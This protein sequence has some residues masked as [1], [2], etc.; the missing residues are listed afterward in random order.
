[1]ASQ[2]QFD[3][4]F[5]ATPERISF[6]Y[7]LAGLGS[8]FLAQLLDLLILAVAVAVLGFGSLAMGGTTGLLVIVL[9]SFILVNGYFLFFEGLWS[10]Q[11]PGKRVARLRVV[12]GSGQPITFE[13]A[14][15]RNLVRNLDFLPIG[16]GVGLIA[17]FAH[18]HGK[19]LGDLAADTV[20]V[21][22]RSSLT[23]A[24][25]V[26]MAQRTLEITPADSGAARVPIDASYTRQRAIRDLEPSLRDFVTAYAGRRPSLGLAYRA[27]LAESARAGLSRALPQVVADHGALAALDQLADYAVARPE[28]QQVPPPSYLPPPVG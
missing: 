24:R 10:G 19:R 15:T 18:G 5:I 11:T 26:T 9:G 12:G 22:E 1:M 4:L 7:Q 27:T 6:S 17:L 25:L 20:V 23:L 21:R 16:Y 14:L 3:G 28:L 13:Q 8:R 2:A